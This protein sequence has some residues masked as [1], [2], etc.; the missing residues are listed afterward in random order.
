[1]K[2]PECGRSASGYYCSQCGARLSAG[3]CPGCGASPGPG[4]RYC[5]DCG[6]R[7]GPRAGG[8]D[9]D[10]AGSDA[11]EP[12]RGGRRKWAESGALG[13]WVAGLLLVALLLSVGY[14]MVRD[15][16]AGGARDGRG[17]TA[18]PGGLGPAPQVDLGSMT[19]IEAADRLYI[20]VT[21]AAHRGDSIEA[22]TF[23]PMAIAAY[24]RAKPLD[25]DGIYHLSTLERIA[26]EQAAA[27]ATALGG[28]A[29]NP[30]HLLILSAAAEAAAELGDSAVARV[31]FA[32]ILDVYD[33]EVAKS[34]EEYGD[35]AP[36]VNS[37]EARAREF[38]ESLDG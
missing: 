4:D 12:R 25:P 21:Q 30:D 17:G 36:L 32:R 28:L 27:L 10:G 15:G 38:V 31:H 22:Q 5:T 9:G 7:L 33:A 8:R 37:L 20:R 6:H 13:W 34:L 26:M 35:H 1:M 19:P 18:T 29:S 11:G 23:L 14:P 16:G 24:E 2:C 3:P